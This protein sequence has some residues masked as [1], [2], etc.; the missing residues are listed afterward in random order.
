VT[1]PATTPGA[2]A[3]LQD[4]LTVTSALPGGGGWTANATIGTN[5]TGSSS[6]QVPNQHI[7]PF[8]LSLWTELLSGAATWSIEVTGDSPLQS[9]PWGITGSGG[10]PGAP[11]VPVPSAWPQISGVS[12]YTTGAIDNPVAAWRL[13]IT[14]G[15]GTVQATAQQAGI[16][17]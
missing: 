14:A 17:N 16:R 7:T 3:T 9:I 4:F 15:A 5:S 12:A 6:W 13:T 10:S 11:P 1:I 2:Y 8:Q